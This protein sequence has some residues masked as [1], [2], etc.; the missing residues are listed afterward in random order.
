MLEPPGRSCF[1]SRQL[2][3]PNRSIAT[4]ANYLERDFCLPFLRYFEYVFARGFALR[5]TQVVGRYADQHLTTRA[6]PFA[7]CVQDEPKVVLR[8]LRLFR[9]GPRLSRESRQREIIGEA[10][11]G[12]L[13]LF[14]ACRY[15]ADGS[16]VLFGGKAFTPFVYRAFFRP[17]RV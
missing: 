7:F 3:R 5:Q 15:F 14:C 2:I 6:R 17:F 4:R 13:G 1:V 10:A 8:R 9:G 16:S 11:Y 12:V